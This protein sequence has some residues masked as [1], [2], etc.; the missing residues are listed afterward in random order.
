VVS[1]V[2]TLKTEIALGMQHAQLS[3]VVYAVGFQILALI[4]QR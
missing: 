1:V 4:A 3:T 2:E